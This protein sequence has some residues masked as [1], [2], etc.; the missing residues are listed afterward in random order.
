MSSFNRAYPKGRKTA[1]RLQLPTL[2]TS[3]DS[4]QLEET[5]NPFGG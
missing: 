4:L 5:D 3:W 1:A 2:Q